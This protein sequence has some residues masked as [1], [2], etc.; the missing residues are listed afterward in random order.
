M[1]RLRNW[2]NVYRLLAEAR[3]SRTGKVEQ[4]H[5]SNRSNTASQSLTCKWG[6]GP[7]QEKQGEPNTAQANV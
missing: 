5:F 6:K 4:V 3:P 7:H 1:H 2:R